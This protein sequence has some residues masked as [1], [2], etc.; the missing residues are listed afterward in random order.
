MKLATNEDIDAPIESV[1]EMFSDFEGFERSAMR[2]GA[3]VQRIDTLSRAGIG[4]VWRAAFTLRGRLRELELQVVTF[5][6]PN[7]IRLEGHI[8]D[9]VG[10]LRFD[11]ISLSRRRTRVHVALE[12]KPITLS[13]RLLVYSLRFGRAS[14]IRKFKSRVTEYARVMED[15]HARRRLAG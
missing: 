15:R 13:A 3:D 7:E 6:P 1:F 10:Q 4:M 12:I 8:S 14:L 11:L 9:M 5:D 2:R